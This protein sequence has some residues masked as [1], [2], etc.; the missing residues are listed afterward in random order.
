MDVLT[1]NVKLGANRSDKIWRPSCS[2]GTVASASWPGVAYRT[3]GITCDCEAAM[4]GG[5]PVCLHCAACW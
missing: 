3:D 5:D 1:R 4:L 2:E